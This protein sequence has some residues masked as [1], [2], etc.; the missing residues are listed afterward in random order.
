MSNS[1]PAQ[2]RG[3]GSSLS[4]AILKLLEVIE[5]ENAV[6]RDHRIVAHAGFTDRK[7][8]ALRELMAAQRSEIPVE[9]AR[10]CKDL[11]RSLSMALHDNA[12]LLKLH[13]GAVGELSD[14]II[15]GLREAESDGTYSRNRNM[16]V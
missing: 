14:I 1:A 6:L 13:I 5:D 3:Q 16:R 9:A 11:L 2:P 15:S 12:G 4:Q 10:S 8:Q 7:N